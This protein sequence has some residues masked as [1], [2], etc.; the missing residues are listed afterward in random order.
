[1]LK[2]ITTLA[3]IILVCV[4]VRAAAAATLSPSLQK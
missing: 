1:M 2:K 4:A 3:A